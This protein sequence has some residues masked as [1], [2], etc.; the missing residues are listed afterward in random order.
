MTD[1]SWDDLLPPGTDLPCEG[2]PR[3]NQIAAK[4]ASDLDEIMKLRQMGR[5]MTQI[6]AELGMTKGRVSGL[7]T[8]GKWKYK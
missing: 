2:I 1:W 4:R 3:S 7:I 6:G 5:S 8:R